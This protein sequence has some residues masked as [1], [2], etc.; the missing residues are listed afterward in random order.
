[1]RQIVVFSIV[2]GIELALLSEQKRKP[3]RDRG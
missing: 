2:F 1:L 3:M